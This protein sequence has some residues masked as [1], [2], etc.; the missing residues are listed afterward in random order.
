MVFW[1]CSAAAVPAAGLAANAVGAR[2]G[3]PGGRGHVAWPF[4][5]PGSAA[6]GPGGALKRRGT[7]TADE[8]IDT[9]L[10]RWR[11]GGPGL[12]FDFNRVL[13]AC[14]AAQAA[15]FAGSLLYGWRPPGRV[16][17]AAFATGAS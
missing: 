5:G 16:P 13:R 2:G 14:T 3:R 10:I 17:G 7:M 4:D 9:L 1:Q 12:R 15:D 11:P 8:Q 6:L